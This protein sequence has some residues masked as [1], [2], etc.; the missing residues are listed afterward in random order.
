ME[1]VEKDA[2]AAAAEDAAAQLRA[3]AAEGAL[4]HTLVLDVANPLSV[5]AAVA[6]VRQRFDQRLDCLVNNAGV[7]TLSWTQRSW[8]TECAP[9]TPFLLS[10]PFRRLSA[11]ADAGAFRSFP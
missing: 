7:N 8:D 2:H 9:L 6:H 11:R 10:H 4:V 5:Q 3:S 1:K